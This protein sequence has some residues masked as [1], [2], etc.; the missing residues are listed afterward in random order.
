VDGFGEVLI[1]GIGGTIS[2]S[3]ISFEN[4]QISYGTVVLVVDVKNGVLSVTPHEPL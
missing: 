2:K 1:E 4:E 3:A